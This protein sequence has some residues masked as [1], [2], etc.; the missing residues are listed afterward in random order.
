[1]LQETNIRRQSIALSQ[2]SAV[3]V[4]FLLDIFARLQKKEYPTNAQFCEI[5]HYLMNLS[6]NTNWFSLLSDQGKQ[7]WLDI[8]NFMDSVITMVLTKNQNELIQNMVS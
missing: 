8:R 1:M 4:K 3:V 5:V 7:C 2:N 6:N